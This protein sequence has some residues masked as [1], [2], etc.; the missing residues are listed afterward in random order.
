MDV[1]SNLLFWIH[2]IGVALGGVAAFGIPLVGRRMPTATADTR[3]LLFSLLEAMSKVGRAA[4]GLLIVTGPLIVWLKFGMGGLSAW[5]W[6]KM[7]LVVLLLVGVIYAGINGKRVEKG[8]MAAARRAP[9]VGMFTA[10]TFLL[11]LLS[12]VFAFN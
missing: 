3:P 9:I 7:V 6:I 1:V 8:D 11:I 12:A 4:I 2:L 5:F 10:G